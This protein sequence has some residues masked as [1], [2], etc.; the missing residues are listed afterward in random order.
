MFRMMKCRLL[1]L[2]VFFACAVYAR[3]D[4]AFLLEEPYGTFGNM[5]PTG[6]AAVYLSGI[7]ADTPTHLRLCEQGEPGVVI[8]RYHRIGGLDWVA[9]PL[10]PYLYAVENASDIPSSVDAGTVNALRD[11]Y[12]RNH[13]LRIAPDTAD[14]APPKGDWTQLV[15][16]AY[17]RRLFGFQIETTPGQ[18]VALVEYLNQSRN[19]TRYSLLTN[20]CAD[21]AA[22]ILNFYAPHSVRRNY[23]ADAGVTTPKLVA[24]SIVK[25]ARRHPLVELSSFRISQVPGTLPRSQHADGV[26]E[27]LV[28]SKKY[29]VP[30]ALLSP[31]V[32]GTIAVVYL[33]EGRFRPE[34]NAETFDLART[35]QAQPSHAGGTLRDSSSMSAEPLHAG[36]LAP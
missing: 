30:L 34:R 15:G 3:A 21:F 24:K 2:F 22:F 6:H 31:T 32:T 19:R 4:A 11:A 10:I 17:D 7:C 28:R 9:I 26:A 8:S 20:N 13:L 5:N 36:P 23:L 18:D 29:I 27:A 16:S 12:R 1:A 35:V 14:G 25:Y 33:A